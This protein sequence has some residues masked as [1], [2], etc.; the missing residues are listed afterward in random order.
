VG[1]LTPPCPDPAQYR[2]EAHPVLVHRPEFD[3]AR[4]A[5]LGDV[6]DEFIF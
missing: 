4:G 5:T 2:L 6:F 1:T 3:H